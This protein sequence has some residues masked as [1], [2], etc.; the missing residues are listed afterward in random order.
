MRAPL[1][2][3]LLAA[4][5]LPASAAV[6]AR[7][8]SAASNRGYV[9]EVGRELSTRADALL[10]AARARHTDRFSRLMAP[11]TAPTEEDAGFLLTHAL[12]D[13][14][15][16]RSI[17]E[18]FR[19]TDPTLGRRLQQAADAFR[20]AG[21]AKGVIR[22][23]RDNSDG[24]TGH[25]LTVT[26]E[27]AKPRDAEVA[28]DNLFDGGWGREALAE[29]VDG[30]A[31]EE[32]RRLLNARYGLRPAE[33][34]PEPGAELEAWLEQAKDGRPRR[35]RLLENI[36]SQP[37]AHAYF[38]AV[39]PE[40]LARLRA[41]PG[42]PSYF[43]HGKEIVRRFR[44]HA[45]E[46]GAV[47]APV[48]GSVFMRADHPRDYRLARFAP[49][50]TPIPEGYV[51]H[52]GGNI[53]DYAYAKALRH[54]IVPATWS[55]EID[56]RA[57]MSMAYHDVF[58]AVALL[59][60]EFRAAV[61]R[62]IETDQQDDFME[63]YFQLDGGQTA[64]V[65][66]MLSRRAGFSLD[67]IP[68]D[69]AGLAARLG[70]DAEALAGYEAR[71][72]DWQGRV[73]KYRATG[74]ILEPERSEGE[75]L[76]AEYRGLMSTALGVAEDLYQVLFDG[77]DKYGAAYAD[78]QSFLDVAMGGRPGGFHMPHAAIRDLRSA[79][80]MPLNTRWGYDWTTP[81]PRRLL[82]AYR[83]VLSAL[84]EA[85]RRTPESAA[86]AII[87]AAPRRRQ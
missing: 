50:G 73:E 37:R 46:T 78:G 1:V 44:L 30:Q 66:D 20:A 60:P 76:K 83:T 18:A 72:A 6:R 47:G 61:M 13:R 45:H 9:L 69:D 85:S 80:A 84:S 87:A 68:D 71:R 52:R 51:M 10:A 19:E 12:L 56:G 8:L 70:I 57:D 63:S 15:A 74:E 79:L 2:F 38:Q 23:L 7:S 49:L 14:R 81:P 62:L 25:Y 58:H 59:S 53:A 22:Y 48:P 31:S 43:P 32:K 86:S 82:P 40:F 21:G 26:L 11:E 75:A 67:S 29:D 54:G 28:L 65:N 39:W 27:G 24:P 16:A 3:L 33:R 5:A 64:R 35:L 55:G 77:V 42:A 41:G 34:G 17:G 4:L 36:E